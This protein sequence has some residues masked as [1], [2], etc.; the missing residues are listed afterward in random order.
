MSD[1]KPGDDPHRPAADDANVDH[2]ARRRGGHSEC[3]AGEGQQRVVEG[4]CRRVAAGADAGRC[5]RVHPSS[6][7]VEPEERGRHRHPPARGPAHRRGHRAAQARHDTGARCRVR[8]G[9]G[10]ATDACRVA[11]RRGSAGRADRRAA[12]GQPRRPGCRAAAHRAGGCACGPGV[13]P[14]WNRGPDRATAPRRTLRATHRPMQSPTPTIRWTAPSATWRP[15]NA[16]CKAC[17]R[18]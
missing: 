10:A 16:S 9:A 8:P 14:A 1:D 15:I 3:H 2:A 18:R 4:H 12:H 6:R 7:A 5:G 11:G 17:W 13:Q